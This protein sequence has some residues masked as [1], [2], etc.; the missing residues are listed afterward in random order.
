MFLETG[1]R[2]EEERMECVMD[3]DSPVGLSLI[4]I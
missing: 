1:D 2:G 4:H 3:S